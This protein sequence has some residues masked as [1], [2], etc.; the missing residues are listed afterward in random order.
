MWEGQ[1]QITSTAQYFAKRAASE[2][3]LL[4]VF[5]S[6]KLKRKVLRNTPSIS[7]TL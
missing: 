7:K 1:N 5:L 4:I 6:F 3:K 2:S